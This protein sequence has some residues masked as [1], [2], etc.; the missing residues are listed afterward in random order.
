M[1]GT[2][3]TREVEQSRSQSLHSQ[4]MQGQLIDNLANVVFSE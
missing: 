2:L 3:D 4:K 1:P